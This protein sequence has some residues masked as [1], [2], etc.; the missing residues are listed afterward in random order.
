M[1][2]HRGAI[3]IHTNQ[4][5]MGDKNESKQTSI[6]LFG[7]T[8]QSIKNIIKGTKKE[9][10]SFETNYDLAVSEVKN[11]PTFSD[12]NKKAI[13]EALSDLKDKVDNKKPVPQYLKDS[14]L[15]MTGSLASIA[16]LFGN[17]SIA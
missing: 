15:S 9:M 11:S 7:K 8:T 3:H 13:L 12:D 17:I 16:S 14:L 6:N 5:I 10:K 4:F 2:S 1:L